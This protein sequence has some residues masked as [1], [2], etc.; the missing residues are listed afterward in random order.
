MFIIVSCNSLE[1]WQILYSLK[2]IA[3]FVCPLFPLLYC[4][5]KSHGI[6]Y[7]NYYSLEEIK[8]NNQK[9]K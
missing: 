6:K 8:G 4:I 1:I 3:G 9:H 7:L 5:Y 2:S